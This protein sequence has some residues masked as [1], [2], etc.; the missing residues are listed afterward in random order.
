MVLGGGTD[1]RYPENY[2]DS[3]GFDGIAVAL[4][5]VGHP[6]GVC[7]SALFFGALRAGAVRLQDP[8]IGLHRVWP[9]IA[10]SL[11]VLAVAG[12]PALERL[13]R[14]PLRWL[15]SKERA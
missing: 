7:V 14:L 4:L 12:K 11:A 2:R 3:Y 8:E 9:E 1:F 6:L 15:S 5:G 10:Q 13:W